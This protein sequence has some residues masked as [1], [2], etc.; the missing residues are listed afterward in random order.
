MQE[1]IT[2]CIVAIAGGIVLYN[3]YKTV[4]SDRKNDHHGCSSACSCDAKT[5][6][7]ELLGKKL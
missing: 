1:I 2:Y 6:R 4:F 3:L 5:M 7:K